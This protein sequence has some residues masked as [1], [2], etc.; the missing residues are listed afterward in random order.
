MIRINL[1]QMML[2]H[3]ATLGELVTIEEIAK[4]TGIGRNTLSRIKNDPYRSTSTEVI[5]KLCIFFDCAIADIMKFENE[6]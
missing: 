1:Q 4:S 3:S 5:N 2:T 6:S